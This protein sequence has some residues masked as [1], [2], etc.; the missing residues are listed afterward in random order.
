MKK[1]KAIALIGLAAGAGFGLYEIIKNEKVRA[2]TTAVVNAAGNIAAD[3]G[4]ATVEGVRSAIN[5]ECTVA[6]AF[7][8]T[9]ALVKDMIKENISDCKSDLEFIDAV[10]DLD[11]AKTEAADMYAKIVI[12]RQT[13]DTDDADTEDEEADGY[14]LLDVE[15]EEVGDADLLDAEDEDFDIGDTEVID[16]EE[17]EVFEEEATEDA[18]QNAVIDQDSSDIDVPSIT[19]K[20]F[21]DK[22]ENENGDDMTVVVI[23]PDET[24]E[25]D[26]VNVEQET[27]DTL[28]E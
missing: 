12:N 27:G 7:T 8:N 24:A 1:L 10:E 6:D 20:Q 2:K 3:V 9:A 13:D 14:D 5:K 21:I 25:D 23:N 17:S 11:D 4:F 28:A 16:P 22:V 19:E 26:T 15:D 18:E